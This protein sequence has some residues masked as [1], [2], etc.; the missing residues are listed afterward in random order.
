MKAYS[1]AHGLA[2]YPSMSW[3]PWNSLQ[4]EPRIFYP[5]RPVEQNSAKGIITQPR[6][7]ID[8][9][10]TSQRRQKGWFI[11]ANYPLPGNGFMAHDAERGG[12]WG[13]SQ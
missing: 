4:Y 9:A 5:A 13:S 10:G 7:V 6:Q 12:G 11:F 8:R 3:N 2:I 1:T